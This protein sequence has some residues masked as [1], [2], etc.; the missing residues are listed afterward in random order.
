MCQLPGHWH[1]LYGCGLCS[2]LVPDVFELND[3]TLSEVVGEVT[4]DN[5]DAVREAAESCPM[6]A[7]SL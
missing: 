2:D 1:I 6:E 4:A 3:E 5:A 7:I